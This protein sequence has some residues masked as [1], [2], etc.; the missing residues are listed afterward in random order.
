[1]STVTALLAG[2]DLLKMG[3]L[4]DALKVFDYSKAVIDNEIALMLKQA[5]KGM[6]FTERN[7]ALETIEEAGPGGSFINK[8]HTIENMRTTPF[9]PDIA[10]RLP[11]NQWEARGAETP[12]AISI[13]R[14]QEILT[15][16][17]PAVFS[18]E[19]DKTIRSEFEELVTGDATSL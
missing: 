9:L 17:N 4:L 15:G 18:P 16:D 8:S 14:V 12:Q 19:L 5:A 6:Q 11:W 3:G 1:M 10:N 7:L 13:K 2:I